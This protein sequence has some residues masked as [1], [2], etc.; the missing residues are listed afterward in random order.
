MDGWQHPVLFL[1]TM[2]V[3]EQKVGK[4]LEASVLYHA[5]KYIF[6]FGSAVFGGNPR[7]CYSPGVVVAVVVQ[8]L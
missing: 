2:Y 3:A 7:Y 1:I 8:K 5:S 4:T 6:L